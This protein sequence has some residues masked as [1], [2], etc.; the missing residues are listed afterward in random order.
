MLLVTV[1]GSNASLNVAVTGTFVAAPDAPAPGEVDVTAGGVVSPGAL[2]VKSHV[3]PVV[4]GLRRVRREGRSRAVEVDAVAAVEAVLERMQRRVVEPVR[5]EEAAVD[6]V[7]ARRGEIGGHVRRVRADE[8]GWENVTV[9]QPNAVSPVNVA[10]AS[11]V[12]DAV[13]RSPQVPVLPAPL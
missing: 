5:G 10:R 1:D 8:T 11:N 3:D 7:V 6:R 13:H 4:A 9:C 2:V 12:P